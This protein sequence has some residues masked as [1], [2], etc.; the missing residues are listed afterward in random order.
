M[1]G[2]I[3]AD[4]LLK[5]GTATRIQTGVAAL[6]GLRIGPLFDNR[7]ET[8]IAFAL[9]HRDYRA[10]RGV[11]G[12]GLDTTRNLVALRGFELPLVA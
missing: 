12:E 10:L 6:K 5:L 1:S 11:H 4:E 3:Q 9:N 7:T 2:V 8:L